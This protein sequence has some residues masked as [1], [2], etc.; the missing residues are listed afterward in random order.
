MRVNIW[1]KRECSPERIE[2][3][4]LGWFDLPALPHVGEY[5]VIH[6]GWASEAVKDVYVNAFDGTAIIEIRPDHTGEYLA[7]LEEKPE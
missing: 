2:A 3:V 5:V 7:A 1:C 6:D 4:D